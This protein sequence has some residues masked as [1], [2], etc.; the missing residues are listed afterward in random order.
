LYEYGYPF[1]PSTVILKCK[2]CPHH[3]TFAKAEIEQAKAYAQDMKK[4][5]FK[6]APKNVADELIKS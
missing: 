5:G 2:K 6:Q 3:I 1:I 4:N